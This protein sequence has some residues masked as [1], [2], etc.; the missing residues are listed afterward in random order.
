MTHRVEP[1]GSLPRWLKPANR[2]VRLMQRLGVPLGTVRV[3]TVLGRASGQPRSTPV[4][5]L[6]VAGR[7][8]L[9]AA[10]P[11][12]DWARN[13]RAA[14]RGDLSSGRGRRPVA[15]REV[16]DPVIRRDVMRAFPREVPGGVRF[17]VRIGLVERADPEQFAAAAD[18]V[19][20]FEITDVVVS[21]RPS[22]RADAHSP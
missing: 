18:R 1:T 10:L 6:R 19:T 21:S 5:P 11:R 8:Y 20:V 3:H 22:E 13:V 16:A 4:S 7:E 17:F 9:I 2:M 12:S 15:L 14:G